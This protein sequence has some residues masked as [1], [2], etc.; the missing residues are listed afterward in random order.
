M[1]KIEIELTK[2]QIYKIREFIH[3]NGYLE[4]SGK[5][6]YLLTEPVIADFREKLKIILLTEK[7]GIEL[8][9]VFE[10]MKLIKRA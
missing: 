3:N 8:Q 7:Q 6:F 5:H 1:K 9:K 2:R 10:K 4:R